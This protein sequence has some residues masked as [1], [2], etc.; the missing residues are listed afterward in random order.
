MKKKKPRQFIKS[1]NDFNP[2]GELFQ[3]LTLTLKIIL[4]FRHKLF[5]YRHPSEWWWSYTFQIR[6]ALKIILNKWNNKFCLRNDTDVFVN[7]RQTLREI[8][9]LLCQILVDSALISLNT[10]I[11]LFNLYYI[12][13]I[14]SP[15]WLK[16]GVFL[17]KWTISRLQINHESIIEN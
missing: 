7:I 6:S 10:K 11:I 2:P 8:T 9:N 1:T 4:F 17:S 3:I 5:L 16:K 14:F 15:K 13:F 12:L